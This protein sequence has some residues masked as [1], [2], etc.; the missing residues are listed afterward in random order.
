MF[1]E[2]SGEDEMF[3]MSH[4][5]LGM[6]QM[7]FSERLRKARQLDQLLESFA[8]DEEEEPAEA[9]PDDS[10]LGATYRRTGGQPTAWPLPSSEH[11]RHADLRRTFDTP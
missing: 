8:G 3:N 4:G 11:T 1:G 9:A 10:W 6:R 7:S 2:V 5:L